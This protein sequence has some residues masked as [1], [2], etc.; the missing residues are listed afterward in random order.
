MA[1]NGKYVTTEFICEKVRQDYGF[2][3]NLNEAMEWI[4]DAFALIGVPQPYINKITDGENTN[5]DPLIVEDYKVLLPTDLYK[6]I[7]VVDYDTDVPLLAAS[8]PFYNRD[9]INNSVLQYSYKIEENYLHTNMEEGNLIISYKALPVDKRG[10][11]LVADD[12]KYIRGV[13]SFIAYKLAY[14]MFIKEQINRQIYE[15]IK[16]DY[17]FNVGAAITKMHIPSLDEMES[18]KNRGLQLYTKEDY[19]NRKFKDFNSKE[20]TY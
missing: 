15:E 7:N 17:F 16:Q 13:V 12:V 20:N 9:Y 6:I 19:H 14:R 10:Y 2:S 1:F 4:Y 5:D 8:V 11:P 3:L 18:L